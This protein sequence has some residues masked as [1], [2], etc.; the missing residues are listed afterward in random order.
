MAFRR[1]LRNL[2]VCDV[3]SRVKDPVLWE[4]AVHLTAEGYITVAQYIMG[5]FA[6]MEA[7]RQADGGDDGEA[8]VKRRRDDEPGAAAANKKRYGDAGNFATRQ[9]PFWRGGRG[10][11]GRGY[12]GGGWGGWCGWPAGGSSSGFY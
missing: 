10:G 7:K 11:G 8:E 5:G 12:R 4:D 6:A 2:K 9:D 1:K 3:G